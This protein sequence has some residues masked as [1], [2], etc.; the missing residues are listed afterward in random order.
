VGGVRHGA[1]RGPSKSRHVKHGDNFIIISRIR[2]KP[3]VVNR[4]L[5]NVKFELD[6]LL[7][8]ALA[9]VADLTKQA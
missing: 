1:G 7:Q 3:D 8:G 5:A 4:S 6:R 2:R 9:R